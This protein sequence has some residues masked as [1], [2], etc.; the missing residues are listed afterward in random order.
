MAA[1]APIAS[2]NVR[3]ATTV[4]TGSSGAFVSCSGG[5]GS[6][7]QQLAHINA[8]HILANSR[9]V[10]EPAAGFHFRLLLGHTFCPMEVRA[11]LYARLNLLL[12]V[13][14][15]EPASQFLENV[16]HA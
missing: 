13:V 16:L 7:F 4:N 3:I 6:F 15:P 12:K 2:A 5:P 10:P 1:F 9:R 14:M 8:S 11:H